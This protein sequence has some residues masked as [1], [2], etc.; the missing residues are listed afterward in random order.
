MEGRP[1][2]RSAPVTVQDVF[3][4]SY[5]NPFFKERG[6]R[7]K[8]RNYRLTAVNGDTAVVHFQ[9]SAGSFP[10]HYVFYVNVGVLPKPWQELTAYD[11]AR[12]G[13]SPDKEPN[14]ANGLY[15]T[16]V[17]PPGEE[18]QW[19]LDDELMLPL[20]WLDHL[21]PALSDQVSLLAALLDRDYFLAYYE[22]G[23]PTYAP[24]TCSSERRSW[25]TRQ[26]RPDSRRFSR[27]SSGSI[28]RTPSGWRSCASSAR[29]LGLIPRAGPNKG[30]SESLDD[31]Q[32]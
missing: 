22:N 10:G 16:R 12:R 13:L 25:L 18:L 23:G 29:V 27:R 31:G 5:V 24:V 30:M 11:Y 3:F 4:R 20:V 8:G 14:V 9:A 2:R 7:R 1:H 21:E 6:F 28:P 32:R 19:L 15:W 26:T 17:D